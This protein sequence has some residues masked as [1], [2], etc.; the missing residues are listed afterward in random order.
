MCLGRPSPEFQITK[1]FPYHNSI[2]K[3]VNN[4][5]MGGLRFTHPYNKQLLRRRDRY[6]FM[7]ICN[8]G[9]SQA[10]GRRGHV[11]PPPVFGRSVIPYLN[12]EDTLCPPH[13]YVP[14]RIFRPCDGP[15]CWIV[16]A[17]WW[18][19]HLEDSKLISSFQ[20]YVNLETRSFAI[21][22]ALLGST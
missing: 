1:R 2:W 21:S 11:S 22:T 9:L 7:S 13:Y 6:R 8:P 4:C 18:S 16:S 15:V 3:A 12:Q 19:F 5:W 20:N 10:G 14:F 17:E